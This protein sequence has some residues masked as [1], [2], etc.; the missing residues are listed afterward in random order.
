MSEVIKNL[1]DRYR[2]TFTSK[3]YLREQIKLL[4][5]IAPTY[6]SVIKNIKGEMLKIIKKNPS[7]S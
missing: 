2:G 4:V 6:F 5:M 3:E 1:E 7:Y